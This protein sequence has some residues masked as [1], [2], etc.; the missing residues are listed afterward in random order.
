MQASGRIKK[1]RKDLANFPIDSWRNDRMDIPHGRQYP[2]DHDGQ[3]AVWVMPVTGYAPLPELSMG[4][5]AKSS[6]SFKS[7]GNISQSPI[8]NS[9]EA[10]VR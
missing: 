6:R 7:P 4:E 1:N 3:M 2:D 5:F 8:D 10:H 9:G